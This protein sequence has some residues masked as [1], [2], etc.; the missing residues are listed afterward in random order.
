MLIQIRYDSRYRTIHSIPSCQRND[1]INP[2]KC[3][4][5]QSELELNDLPEMKVAQLEML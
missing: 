4:I 5:A 3:R 2:K 1:V